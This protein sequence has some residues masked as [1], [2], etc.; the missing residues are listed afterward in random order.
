M[1]ELFEQQKSTSVINSSA[2]AEV[3]HRWAAVIGMDVAAIVG[4]FCAFPTGTGASS[5]S[6]GSVP[7]DY[8]ASCRSF[9]SPPLVSS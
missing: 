3:V 8:G 5:E 4:H 2:P 1:T 6:L 9:S 7:S